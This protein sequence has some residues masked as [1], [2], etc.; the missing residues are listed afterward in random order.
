MC[1]ILVLQLWAR[2]LSALARSG[3]FTGRL[4]RQHFG[5]LPEVICHIWIR[6]GIKLGLVLLRK[7]ALGRRWIA[8]HCHGRW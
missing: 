7:A 1:L 8:A 2:S 5:M 3:N 4:Q 6:P